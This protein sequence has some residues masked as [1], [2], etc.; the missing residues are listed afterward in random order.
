M[1]DRLILLAEGHMVYSGPTKEVV[2]Y[3][4]KLGYE[5]P[6]Y[7]NPAEFVSKNSLLPTFFFV[8]QSLIAFHASEPREEG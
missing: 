1:F 7:T 3:F 6:K 2:N 5:C 8:G 4:A